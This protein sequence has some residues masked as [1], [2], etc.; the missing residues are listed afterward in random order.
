M[1]IVDKEGVRMKTRTW[2]FG[3][4]L[5]ASL[6]PLSSEQFFVAGSPYYWKEVPLLNPSTRALDIGC[7]GQRVFITAMADSIGGGV[8]E[9]FEPDFWEWEKY[10][11]PKIVI[12][13]TAPSITVDS[14]GIPWVLHDV[15]GVDMAVPMQWNEATGVWEFR[16]QIDPWTMLF[17]RDIGA[18]GS[19]AFGF[20]G[21]PGNVSSGPSNYVLKTF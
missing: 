18:G 19:V 3:F 16:M 11:T 21:K 14:T 10:Y 20:I 4:L 6:L 13:E 17:A 12:T 7:G 9:L 15:T 5:L 1:R 8:M 2:F